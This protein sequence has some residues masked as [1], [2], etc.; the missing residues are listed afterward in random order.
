VGPKQF[1][2]QIDKSVRKGEAPQSQTALIVAG[3]GTWSR[4]QAYLLSSVG[5]LLEMRLLDRLREALGGTYSVSVGT[6]FSRTP[7]QSGRC[8]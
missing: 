7:R 8:R 4:D 6:S 2:G 5:E 1:N 3:A